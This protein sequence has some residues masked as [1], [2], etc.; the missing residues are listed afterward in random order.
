[1]GV[2]RVG[3]G[4]RPDRASPWWKDRICGIKSTWE[5]IAPPAEKEKKTAGGAWIFGILRGWYRTDRGG[6]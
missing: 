4:A 3:W 6:A 5:E 1:M 2:S